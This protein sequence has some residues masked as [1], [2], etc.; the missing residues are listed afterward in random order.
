[1]V[2]RRTRLDE[3]LLR[4]NTKEQARF[5][6]ETL[7]AD[8]NDYVT[9]DITYKKAL[10]D[11]ES[12]LSDIGRL[13]VI[14]RGFLPNFIFAEKDIVVVIGQDG[15]V[16]NTLKYVLNK[17]VIAVN[18]DPQRYDGLLLPF[19]VNDLKTVTH[20][21]MANSRTDRLITIAKAKLSDGQS[22]LAVNDF[23]IG[24]AHHTSARYQLKVDGNSEY[25][26]SSGVIVSTG[27][28]ATG[29][30]KSILAGAA[31]LAQYTGHPLSTN[32]ITQ[33][34]TW[35]SNSLFY[36]VREPFPSHTT[37]TKLVFGEITNQ[38]DFTM[39]SAMPDEGVIFSD[40]LL[41]DA[42]DFNSGVS[43]KIS[44]AN[45]KRYLVV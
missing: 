23:F 45:E 22:L 29:W 33:K 18:P 43:A 32:D 19:L 10:A 3:L 38:S 13:H 15:L 39:I 30:L 6:V 42:I 17:P 28:G 20:E 21:V 31:A 7:G 12:L 9:E 36:S 34:L 1:M 14:E 24:P 25:Q 8:F 37:G 4:H 26:S 2:T 40:G 11:A 44:I 5:Y 16:A 35:D 41:E 27:L